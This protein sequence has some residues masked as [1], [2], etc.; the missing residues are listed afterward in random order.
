METNNRKEL[1]NVW[2]VI[3]LLIGVSL[4]SW[5]LYLYKLKRERFLPEY[6]LNSIFVIALIFLIFQYTQLR[7]WLVYTIW[8]TVALVLFVLSFSFKNDVTLILKSGENAA[9][10]LKAPFMF[11]INYLLWN[12]V[13]K[14]VYN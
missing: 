12:S 8:M 14:K 6:F 3:W 4:I 9:L 2:N 11:L 13:S 10:L 5:E 1:L 7:K